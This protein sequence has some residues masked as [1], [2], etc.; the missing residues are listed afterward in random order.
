MHRIM[1][2]VSITLGKLGGFQGSRGGWLRG[3][4]HGCRWSL[5][6]VRVGHDEE[7]DNFNSLTEPTKIFFSLAR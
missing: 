6:V 2:P 1:D 7:P 3:H 5:V 4:G